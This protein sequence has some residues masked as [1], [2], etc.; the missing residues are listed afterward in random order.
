MSKRGSK[1]G[2][3]STRHAHTTR[4]AQHT[5]RTG[6]KR[7]VT[8]NTGWVLFHCSLVRHLAMVLCTLMVVSWVV[9]FFRQSRWADMGSS[10]L[11]SGPKWIKMCPLEH[12]SAVSSD[13]CSTKWS[14]MCPTH[15]SEPAPPGGGWATSA[16]TGT[17]PATSAMERQ[18]HQSMHGS[19]VTTE[20]NPWHQQHTHITLVTGTSHQQ[21]MWRCAAMYHR[22]QWI[23][24]VS[25]YKTIKEWNDLSDVQNTYPLRQ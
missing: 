19:V 12:Q 22:R 2:V 15:L 6:H 20:V 3:T 8:Q 16:G 14:C 23:V 18:V 10:G 9:S 5:D 24:T 13:R 21:H 4:G 1:V 25:F 7:E 11:S 17:S